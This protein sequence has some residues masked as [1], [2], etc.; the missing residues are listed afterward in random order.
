MLKGLTSFCRFGGLSVSGKWDFVA[1]EF[2]L[3]DVL[4]GSHCTILDAVI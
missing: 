2:C 3:R 1:V 4:S